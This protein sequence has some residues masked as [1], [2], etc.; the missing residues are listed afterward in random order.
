MKTNAVNW[1]EISVNDLERAV[2]F[3]SKLFP[4]NSFERYEM[5]ETQMAMFDGNPD[6]HGA[7]GVLI[8][9]EHLKPSMEGTTVYFHCD[10]VNN[11][12]AILEELK[13]EILMPKTSIGEHGFIAQFVDCEGN[14]IS[15]HS[16]K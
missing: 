9:H 4:Q 10:D 14:R 13:A 5:E 7:A 8:K 11:Q 6:I 12:L 2:T 15:L 16:M 1:F 3:Y